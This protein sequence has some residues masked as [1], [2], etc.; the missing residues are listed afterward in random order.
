MVNFLLIFGYL[1]A[2]FSIFSYVPYVRDIFAGKAKP[3]RASWFI[4]TVLVFIQFFSQLTK[5][6]HYSLWLS[7]SQL[8]GITLIFLLS[9]KFGYGRLR[10]NDYIA[11]A[12]AGLGLIFWY[13][14]HD[15]ALALWIT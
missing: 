2:F 14:T 5:G 13:I 9:L 12:V 6:A 15:A 7:G 8:F 4:W 11:L 10:R 3:E 1:S